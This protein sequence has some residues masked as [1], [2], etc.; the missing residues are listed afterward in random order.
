MF[1]ESDEVLTLV[2]SYAAHLAVLREQTHFEITAFGVPLS[3]DAIL[4]ASSFRR[5][6]LTPTVGRPASTFLQ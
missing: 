5:G 4:Q 1:S 6:K 3:D 2:K